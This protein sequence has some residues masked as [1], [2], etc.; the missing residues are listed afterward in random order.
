[1]RRQPCWI[2]IS[3]LA[4]DIVI[5]NLAFI[6]AYF[7]RFRLLPVWKGV[8]PFTQYL[9][10]LPLISV[11]LPLI[12]LYQKLYRPRRERTKIADIFGIGIGVIASVVIML[13][14][15]LYYR[16]YYQYQPEVAPR[17]EVSQ[18]VLAIFLVIDI[19]G[20]YL[21]R[22]A[23]RNHLEEAWRKGLY[24]QRVIIAGAGDLGKTLVDK[25]LVHDEL[26]LKVIGFLDDDPK[27]QGSSYH[28]I[29]VLGKLSKLS[30]V[31][32]ENKVD[33]LYLALPLRAH[34]KILDLLKDAYKEGIDVHLIPD[35]LEFIALKAEMEELE[36]LPVI[37][38][39]SVP[40]GGWK[41]LIKRAIDILIAAFGLIIMLVLLPFS[42]LAIKLDSKG[43]VFYRQRRT[44]V[45]GR[46]FTLCKFRS[47]Y[48][49]AEKHTGPVWAKENDPRCTR[50]G[51]FLR[52][53]NLD[54]LPQFYNV[55][56]GDMSVV[57]PRPE[58]PEFVSEF[59]ERI[60]Q[61]MLRH[62]V[63]SGI[64]GWA[65]VNGWRGN[66]SIRK[67]IEHDIYYIENWTLSFDI[68]IIFLTFLHLLGH[69][70]AH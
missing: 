21:F 15:L 8:P 68:K 10:F 1:M 61:Y 3:L 16:I 14:L 41:S 17:Y 2:K 27:K 26:G 64:T 19:S 6:S 28:N 65:Q 37:N 30:R 13:G 62:K 63:K 48:D 12:F 57:G 20:L 36:G 45:D 55:L 25:I 40:L 50:V 59:K 33:K 7:I 43:P 38:L 42:A 52:R 69:K 66:T 70:K 67:R 22:R 58:R 53:F 54:E 60:P 49:D 9:K 56:K 24:L 11:I 4:G 34:D 46:V 5:T 47:M 44:G 29:P 32:E 39:C 31:I 23:V 51:R 18:L 35:L